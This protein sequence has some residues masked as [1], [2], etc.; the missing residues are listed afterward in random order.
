MLNNTAANNSQAGFWVVAGGAFQRNTAVGNAGPGVIVQF[1]V[2][3][4]GAEFASFTQNNFYG[5]DRNRTAMDISSANLADVNVAVG[6]SAHCGVLNAG[7]RVAFPGDLPNP[8]VVA[9][10]NANGNFWGSTH[11]P[12]PTG[13]ADAVGGACDKNGGKTTATSYASVGFAVTTR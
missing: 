6:H 13:A 3:R 8:P 4:S 10:L 11:G 5:N 1:F 9:T 2:D 12:S 7:Q